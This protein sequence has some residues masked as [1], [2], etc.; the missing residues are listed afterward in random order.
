M[1]YEKFIGTVKDFNPYTCIANILLTNGKMVYLHGG[2]FFS[3]RPL[4]LPLI[5]E[6][7]QAY[8]KNIN[9]SNIV[10]LGKPVS[11]V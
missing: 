10:V 3:G 2:A 1:N 8:I 11:G 5:G 9:K 7:V 4:R 6:K